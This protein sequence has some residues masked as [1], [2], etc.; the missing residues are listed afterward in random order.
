MKKP[1][2]AIGH[3]GNPSQVLDVPLKDIRKKLPRRVLSESDWET[4]TT[5]GY[6]VIPDAVPPDHVERLKNLLWAFQEMDPGDPS[7]WDRTDRRAHRMQELNNS[8][9]VE[10]YHHQYLWDNRQYP[11]VYDAFV[12]IW[13]RE[14]LWVTIDRANLNPPNHS[15]RPFEG[16]IHW[17]VD[18]SADP[19][20]V[21]VQ[22]VLSLVDTD[23]EVGGF[24]CVPEL[25]RTLETWLA[26]QPP[27]RDP[28]KPDTTGFETKFIP[29][30][31]GDLLI[32]NSLLPHGIRPNTSKNRVRMAQYI[33]MYPADES[34]AE[35]RAWRIHSWREREPPKGVAFPGDPRGWEKTRYEPARLSELGERLLGLRSWND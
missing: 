10:I 22:G 28:Y 15:H 8:G 19:L 27:G 13:D 29:M 7:T 3:E 23:P 12:D 18:T 26:A 9:M 16:F 34:N 30:K 4:W 25:F 1:L 24:Q 14:D 6:V 2:P 5:W 32:F 33:S 17:D 11:R 31:A 20:P 21:N 35:R